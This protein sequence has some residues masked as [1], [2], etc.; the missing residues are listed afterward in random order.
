MKFRKTI[1][2]TLIG[3]ALMMTLTGCDQDG[4]VE[5]AGEAVDETVEEAGDSIEDA[6]D[7]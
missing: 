7:G 6:T 4:P 1:A 5:E 2:A 3:G